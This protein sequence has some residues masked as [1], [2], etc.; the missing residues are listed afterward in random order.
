MIESETKFDLQ[1]IVAGL[2]YGYM[3]DNKRHRGAYFDCGDIG[4]VYIFWNN[5]MWNSRWTTSDIEP[6]PKEIQR[7]VDALTESERS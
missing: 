7:Q 5:G 1:N 3:N 2:L 4:I 6:L